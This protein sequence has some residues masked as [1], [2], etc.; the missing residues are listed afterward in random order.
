[1]FTAS[2]FLDL[3]L[4]LEANG[5]RF[6]RYAANSATRDSLKKMFFWL[7]DQELRHK[8]AFLEIREK[9]SEET[10]SA[11]FPPI[12]QE[13][14]RSAMGCHVFSLDDFDVESIR[15]EKEILHA[16]IV[17]EEDATMFFEFIARFV[18]DPVPL[19]TID[20]IIK[21]ELNHKLLLM[22]MMPEAEGKSSETAQNPIMELLHG[23]AD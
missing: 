5:E 20:R 1:M 23:K 21:E 15:D 18:S 14:L 22:E 19:A 8:D 3:A 2:E 12:G 9:I 11:D 6:Y 10:P 17:F 13:A 4:Q 16:A 7:A